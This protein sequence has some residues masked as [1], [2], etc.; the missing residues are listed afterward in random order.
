MMRLSG[1]LGRRP[2]GQGRRPPYVLCLR[3]PWIWDRF[4]N[5]DAPADPII[6]IPA[7]PQK[8]GGFMGAPPMDIRR[9]VPKFDPKRPGR[10]SCRM[11]RGRPCSICGHPK[12][13]AITTMLLNGSPS[14]EVARAFGVGP[15][16]IARHRLHCMG[17]LPSN[18][19]IKQRAAGAMAL[20]VLPTADELGGAYESIRQRADAITTTAEQSGSLAVALAGVREM[21]G[22]LDSVGRLAGL[23]GGNGATVNV[24]RPRS[25]STSAR[26]S[27]NLPPS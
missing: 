13:T 16:A 12:L 19:I 1:W 2:S 11:S 10:Y 5:N 6:A 25:T 9:T 4:P 21:R 17:A 24:R 18:Q 23:I 22:V 8:H 7:E 20:A 14:R 3:Q 27:G 26:P 15:S